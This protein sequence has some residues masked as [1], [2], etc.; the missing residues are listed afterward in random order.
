MALKVTKAEVWS[1]EIADEPGALARALS[2]VAGAGGSLEGVIA[3]RQTDKPGT[4]LVFA[5]PIKGKKVKVA[6]SGAG[7]Q[8]AANLATLRV[9]GTDKPGLGARITGAIAEAG[10]NLRGLSAMT[11]GRNFVAYLGFDSAEDAAKAART[12]KAV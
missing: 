11:C 12:L 7:M 8:P 1:A 6:A 3:R 9:E 10:V 5:T 2:A 4:G